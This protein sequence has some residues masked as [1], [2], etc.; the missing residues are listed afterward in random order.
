[1]TEATKKATTR[2]YVIETESGERLIRAKSIVSATQHVVRDL[3]VARVASTDDVARI[4]GAGVRVE[5]ASEPVAE[6]TPAA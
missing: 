3:V 6:P 4:V 5:D 1:M 2:L